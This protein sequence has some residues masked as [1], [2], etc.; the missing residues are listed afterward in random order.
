MTVS[1]LALRFFIAAAGVYLTVSLAIAVVSRRVLFARPQPRSIA[2]GRS[3]GVLV[4]GRSA[5]NRRVAA[6]WF[7]ASPTATVL[8]YFHGNAM[9]LADCV[10]L[11]PMVLSHGWSFYAVEYPGYGVLSENSPSEESVVDVAR[12]A[13]SLLRRTLGVPRERT[14]LVGQSLGSGVA[15]ALAASGEGEKLVLL[16][17]FTSVTDL[18]AGLFPWPGVRWL[19]RDRFDNFARAPMVTLPTLIVHGTRDEVV[20]YVHAERLAARFAHGRL[21]TL[22]G[23]HHNDLWS[24]HSAAVFTALTEFISRR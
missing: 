23:A 21:V 22:A 17:P 2:Y 14:V 3:S 6:L 16:T 1:R 19:V 7:E 13:L 15:T 20:P 5:K 8:V 18:A 11:A 24:D 4:E 12:G 10:D 9:Q